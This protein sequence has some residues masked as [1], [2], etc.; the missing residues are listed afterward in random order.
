MV[1]DVNGR[2]AFVTCPIDKTPFRTLTEFWRHCLRRHA[3]RM[4]KEGDFLL[5]ER[6][7]REFR[8]RRRRDWKTNEARRQR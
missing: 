5:Q 1:S 6:L 4:D 7:N 8:A 3:E 2:K